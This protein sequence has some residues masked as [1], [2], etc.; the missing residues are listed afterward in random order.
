MT[1]HLTAVVRVAVRIRPLLPKEVLHHHRV[2]VRVVPG[3]GQVM[4]GEDRCFYFDNAFGPSVSQDEVYESCVHLLVERL[5]NGENATVFCY[6]Q[7][8]SG[9]MYTLGGR[10]QE[11]GIIDRAAQD[12]F[13][14]LAEKTKESDVVDV[15]VKVS[16]I[17]VYKEELRDLLQREDERGN[18]GNQ[19]FLP[20]L[21]F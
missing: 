17:E 6:G 4:V 18:M 21:I 14:Y 16:Y 11:G 3:T 19:L 12:L 8:G 20:L 7:T 13:I 2:C 5:V 1:A 9:K 15:T 10:S